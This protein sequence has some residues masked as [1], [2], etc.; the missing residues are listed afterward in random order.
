MVLTTD[1]AWPKW[2]KSA[3]NAKAANFHFREV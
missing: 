3:A 1:W 2:G